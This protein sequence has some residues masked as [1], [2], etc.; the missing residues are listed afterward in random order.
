MI[1][2]AIERYRRLY[3]AIRVESPWRRAVVGGVAGLSGA[4]AAETLVDGLPLRL[5]VVFIT[6][7]A[8]ALV[9]SAFCTSLS[10]LF[11]YCVDFLTDRRR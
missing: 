9:V 5:V 8:V 4:I 6:T 7:V 11:A 3:A 1:Q 2:S 10:R